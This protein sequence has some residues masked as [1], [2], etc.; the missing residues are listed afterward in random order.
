[1]A[2]QLQPPPLQNSR[3]LSATQKLLEAEEVPLKPG[4]GAFASDDDDDDD[5][6]S[7][8]EATP[9]KVERLMQVLEARSSHDHL[10]IVQNPSALVLLQQVAGRRRCCLRRLNLSP[11]PARERRCRPALLRH[12]HQGQSQGQIAESGHVDHEYGNLQPR[13][14]PVQELSS[15]HPHREDLVADAIGDR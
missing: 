2:E 6:N 5:E 12:R 10:N 7:M 15:P 8:G 13:A 14:R 1:M 3:S 4:L 11:L 9:C